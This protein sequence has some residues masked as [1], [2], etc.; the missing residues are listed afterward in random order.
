MYKSC[1]AII[2][3]VIAKQRARKEQTHPLC[4]HAVEKYGKVENVN[5]KNDYK[6]TSKNEQTKRK[7]TCSVCFLKVIKFQGNKITVK[8][9]RISRK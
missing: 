4:L 6:T 3:R 5:T 7:Q 1:E 8:F 9:K 2:Y